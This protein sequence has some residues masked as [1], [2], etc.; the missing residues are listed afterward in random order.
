MGDEPLNTGAPPPGTDEHIIYLPGERLR[1][2]R[3]RLVEGQHISEADIELLLDTQ[4]ITGHDEF[5][6]ITFYGTRGGREGL[7]QLG[8]TLGPTRAA[9]AI[10]DAED[11]TIMTPIAE[12]PTPIAASAWRERLDLPA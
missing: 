9:M 8:I 5:T 11:A 12:R 6:P 1:D 7:R 4:N 2:L 10:V 3:V